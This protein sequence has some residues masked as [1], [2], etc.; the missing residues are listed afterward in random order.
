M[1]VSPD[2]NV[3][4]ETLGRIRALA[5]ERDLVYLPAHDPDAAGRLARRSVLNAPRDVHRVM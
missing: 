4:R 1:G 3:A 2:E 5:S